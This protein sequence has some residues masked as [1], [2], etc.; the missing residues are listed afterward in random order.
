M[1]TLTLVRE[2]SSSVSTQ[3]N[4]ELLKSST[5]CVWVM[6]SHFFMLHGYVC[7]L[8]VGK[9]DNSNCEWWSNAGGGGAPYSEPVGGIHNYTYPI[10]AHER[11]IMCDL[12]ART[13]NNDTMMLC[14]FVVIVCG[15]GDADP[16]VY[17]GLLTSPFCVFF[18]VGLPYRGMPAVTPR[19]CSCR[20]WN[21]CIRVLFLSSWYTSVWTSFGD[22]VCC[23]F[24]CFFFTFQWS[25]CFISVG[26]VV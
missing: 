20:S 17:I 15:G 16:H 13:N 3:G 5:S 12:N 25:P 19:I 18:L 8:T 11:E 14:I 1:Q 2:Q 26:R 7:V 23:S 22:L 4:S 9:L 24:M 10:F 6:K 21:A